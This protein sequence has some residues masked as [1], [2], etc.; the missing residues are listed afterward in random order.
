[1]ATVALLEELLKSRTNIWE[2]GYLFEHRVI[3]DEVVIGM[4]GDVKE[5]CNI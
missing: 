4:F 3:Q 1:M 5:I 2:K